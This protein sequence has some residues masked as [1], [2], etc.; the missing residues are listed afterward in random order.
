MFWRSFAKTS[1]FAT[2]KGFFGLRIFVCTHSGLHAFPQSKLFVWVASQASTAQ[3]QPFLPFKKKRT[4]F[5]KLLDNRLILTSVL[6]EKVSF[7]KVFVKK[8]L[9]KIFFSLN[10]SVVQLVQ[11]S[12]RMYSSASYPDTSP[13]EKWK[14]KKYGNVTGVPIDFLC[15]HLMANLTP[16][17]FYDDQVYSPGLRRAHR[18]APTR[19]TASTPP[20]SSRPR[21]QERRS[22][23][24]AT[25]RSS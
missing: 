2:P 9:T 17:R 12:I 11:Q 4:K 14:T 6:L 13:L 15:A 10:F 16:K 8:R 3:R 7:Q 1:F 25:T 21:R 24:S 22:L 5:C 23:Q 19:S 20:R 18:R